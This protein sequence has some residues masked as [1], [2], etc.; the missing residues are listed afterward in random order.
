MSPHRE[1]VKEGASPLYK[2]TH[3]KGSIW[4][5]GENVHLKGRFFPQIKGSLNTMNL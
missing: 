1:N 5:V 4:A 3:R 2:G